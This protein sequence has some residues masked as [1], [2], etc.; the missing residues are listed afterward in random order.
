MCASRAGLLPRH[1]PFPFPSENISRCRREAQRSSAISLE[2]RGSHLRWCL[3]SLR[4]RISVP[5]IYS[6]LTKSSTAHLGPQIYCF[7]KPV[8]WSA[9]VQLHAAKCKVSRKNPLFKRRNTVK[10]LL[11]LLAAVLLLTTATVPCF[12]D[13][14]P[15][16]RGSQCPPGTICPA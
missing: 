3:R 16:P 11:L 9:P 6:F 1:A 8:K 7:R 4:E 15:W 5:Q 2:V 14:N 13:G 10:K 12:A